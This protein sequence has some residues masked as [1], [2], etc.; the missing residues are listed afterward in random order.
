VT[1]PDREAILHRRARF[2]ARALA[3]AGIAA[4]T[5]QGCGG[6]NTTDGSGGNAGAAGTGGSAGNADSGKDT[7]PEPCL[8]V[9]FD[10]AADADAE[11]QP[12]LA[13]PP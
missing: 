5:A 6:D 1:K 8:G 10:A 4:V 3:A 9:G 11:P 13:P 12:C 7:G 2:V